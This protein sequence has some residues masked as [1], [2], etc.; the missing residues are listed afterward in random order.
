M[1]TAEPAIVLLSGGLDSATTL[2]IARNEGFKPVALSF[3]YGQRHSLELGA[4]RNVAAA[5]GVTDHQFIRID[6]G[7]FAGSALTDDIPVPKNQPHRAGT[8]PVTYVPARNTIFLAYA[9]AIAEI[10]GARAIYIGVNAV[11]YSGYPDCRPNYISAFN[12]VAALAT[13]AAVEDQPVRIRAPLLL[14]T[15]VQII[16]LG[17]KL[18]VDYGLT[19][20]CYDPS[21]DGLSCGHCESCHLRLAAFKQTGRPDP[22]PYAQ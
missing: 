15:K 21:P 16:R 8:I 19:R 20:S 1:D 6:P 2:A 11:D 10:R 18:G 9:L 22:A 14:M 5:L 13:K 4:A 17:L 12:R 3:H 7:C